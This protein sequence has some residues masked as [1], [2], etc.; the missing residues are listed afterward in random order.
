MSSP[1][2]SDRTLPFLLALTLALLTPAPAAMANSGATPTDSFAYSPTLNDGRKWR[3]GYY[4]GGPY[5]NYRETLLAMV[6]GLTELGWLHPASPPEGDSEDTAGVW[7]WLSEPGRSEYIEFVSDA[8]HDA[9]WNDD[10]R[11]QLRTDLVR[12][13]SENRDIDLMIAMGTW[14]GR[15][16]AGSAHTTP[17]I[18][19]STSDA[20]RAGIVASVEDSGRD[21]VHAHVDPNR[22]ARQI[23]TFHDIVGFRK[24]GIVYQDSVEGRSYSGIALA[25]EVA[26]A[27][28]F[29]IVR[30][31]LR[32]DFGDEARVEPTVVG[33]FE[34][35]APEVDALYVVSQTGVN[36]RTLP[37]L[38]E[39]ADAS[40]LP[41][42]SQHG[43]GDVREGMLLSMTR[44][45]F[46]GVGMFNAG[47]IARILNG[48]SP[49][50]LG[51]IFEEEAQIGIN[52]E[53]AARI[54][55]VPPSRVLR[56]AEIVPPPEGVDDTIVTDTDS[57]SNLYVRTTGRVEH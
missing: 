35:L 25:D 54:G 6:R 36:D 49:R 23:S 4:Q 43:F 34:L 28:G 9:D 7:N 29:Q 5:G 33:C 53:T 37:A 14:A 19:T 27:R 44:K 57:P 15:D 26:R 20:V 22:F 42:F 11:A 38:I 56:V 12:R 3:I 50:Q 13:L 41:T 46:D 16:V 1:I 18:V 52:L 48:A 39:I 8:Y 17:T 21:H 51:Q 30:C 45:S 10:R 32:G 55:F 31:M 2:P 24:L 40:N 47:V